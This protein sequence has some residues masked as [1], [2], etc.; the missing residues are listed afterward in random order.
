MNDKERLARFLQC[1]GQGTLS[2][3]RSPGPLAAACLAPPFTGALI[4]LFPT[5]RF[6]DIIAAA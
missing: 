4:A 3:F 5:A 2:G 6:S 1:Q